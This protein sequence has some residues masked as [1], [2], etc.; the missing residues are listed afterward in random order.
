MIKKKPREK[1]VDYKIQLNIL[2]A[3]I[4]ELICLTQVLS[5][6]LAD[7]PKTHIARVKRIPF[8]EVY[9]YWEER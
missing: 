8:V 6:S 2:T 5:L 4:S 3:S 7:I 9:H 1:S